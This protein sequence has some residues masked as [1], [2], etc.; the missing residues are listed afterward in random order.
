[1]LLHLLPF[2]FYMNTPH[3]NIKTDPFKTTTTT[4]THLCQTQSHNDEEDVETTLDFS[5]SQ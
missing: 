3:Y 4:T 2:T 1:M 5:W